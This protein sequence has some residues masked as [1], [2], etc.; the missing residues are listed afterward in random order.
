VGGGVTVGPVLNTG[1]QPQKDPTEAAVRQITLGGAFGAGV[2]DLALL[3]GYDPK[4]DTFL[5][6]GEFPGFGTDMSRWV[7]DNIA[8]GAGR[9]VAGNWNNRYRAVAFN[10]VEPILRLRTGAA[11]PI[12]EQMAYE[13]GLLPQSGI[14]DEENQWRIRKLFEHVMIY[15][16]VAQELGMTP[17]SIFAASDEMIQN[18]PLLQEV[19]K[20]ADAKIAALEARE[21]SSA[22]APAQA[23]PGQ[24]QR[25]PFTATLPG[26]MLMEE[27]IE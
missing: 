26:G 9:Y 16:Q 1:V 7:E 2:R 8:G 5:G 20:R 12:T 27:V 19:R 24:P 11:A 14:S 6:G 17:E 23:A 15:E 3:T 25:K 13:Y 10:T 18:D 21:P 22:G 4:T